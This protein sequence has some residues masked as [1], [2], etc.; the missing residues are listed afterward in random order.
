MNIFYV[1]S[2]PR[3][4]ST[5]LMN[6]LG[7][8]PAHYVTPTSGLIE[9]FVAQRNSWKGIT[10][11]RA[12]GLKKVEPR[13]RGSLK[14]LIYGFF[15]QELLNNKVVFD[16]AR[17]WL[18]YVEDLEN[19]MGEKVK[20]ICNV[21]DPREIV[22]SFEKLYRKRGLEW[23]YPIGDGYTK[24]QSV[25]GRADY[26]LSETSMVGRAITRL[27]DALRRDIKS[28]IIIVPFSKL[29]S[30]PHFIM[31]E[32]HEALSL[33]EFT[34]DPTNVVQVTHEEDLYHGMNLHKI[35]SEI[36]PVEPDWQKILSPTYSDELANRY[37]DIIQMAR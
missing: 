36:K 26:L 2:L 19:V 34:Y 24:C 7:Q 22:A 23:D 28:R 35:N 21:R 33:P 20:V 3:S 11:F 6:L 25:E 5:L 17:G 30:R 15:E 9:M 14:G 29:T 18:T 37:S 1:S 8:N 13:V 4:G 16:K 10:E 27:R 31:R 32:L 12:E